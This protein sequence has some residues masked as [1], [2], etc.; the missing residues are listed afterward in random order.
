MVIGRD[1][2]LRTKILSLWHS[3]PTGGHSGI[4]AT[5]RKVL[6]YFYWKG[7]RS[8]IA[9]FVK[10]CV[11]CQRNKY[12]TSASPGLLQPLPIPSLHWTDICMDFI[13]GLPKSKGRTIIWVIVDRLTK[14]RHFIALSHSYSAQSLVPI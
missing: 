13:E 14:S 4:D 3:T 1:A 12:D 11:I 10:K 6:T 9:S 2:T 8:D 5:T 7:I